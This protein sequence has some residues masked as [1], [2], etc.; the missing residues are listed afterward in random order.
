MKRW[1]IAMVT[2]FLV[3]GCSTLQ[4]QIDSDPGFDFASLSTFNVM[5]TK[6]SDE[7]DF[8]RSRI[9]KML[10]EYFENKGYLSTSKDE[11]EFYLIVHL[12]IKTKSEIETNYETMHVYPR[13]DYYN[14]RPYRPIGTPRMYADPYPYPADD[15]RTVATTRTYEYEEGR[16]VI[17]LLDVKQNAVVWQGIAED[18]LSDLPTQEAKSAYIQKVL[19]EMFGDFPSKAGSLQK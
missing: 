15:S 2:A 7:R 9:S 1:L 6:K 14:R 4:V 13:T 3:S 12:D 5:Y 11:A 17:E 19:D 16:L 8:T 18:E 10:T